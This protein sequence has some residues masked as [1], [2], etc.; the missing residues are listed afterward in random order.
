MHIN[1]VPVTISSVVEVSFSFTDSDL[2]SIFL[3]YCK[4]VCFVL[5][6]NSLANLQNIELLRSLFMSY[7]LLS[8]QAVSETILWSMAVK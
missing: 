3:G 6:C 7:K 1:Y 5:N 8:V 4:I 2:F